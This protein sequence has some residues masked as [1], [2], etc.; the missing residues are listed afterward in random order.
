MNI[1]SLR[2]CDDGAPE[3]ISRIIRD[4][5]EE[6]DGDRPQQADEENRVMDSESKANAALRCSSV[7]VCRALKPRCSGSSR[8]TP[9]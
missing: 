4:Y 8:A 7:S 1:I 2:R 6:E 5:I 3:K 9:G